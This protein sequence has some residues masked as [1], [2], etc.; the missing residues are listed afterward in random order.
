MWGGGRQG[1]GE[2]RS[3]GEG[4][5]VNPPEIKSLVCPERLKKIAIIS[6]N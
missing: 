1:R 4:G 5:H 6:V 2:G 3:A